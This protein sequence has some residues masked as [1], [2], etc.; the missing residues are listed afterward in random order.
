MWL[1]V[2]LIPREL[3]EYGLTANKLRKSGYVYVP[4][5]SKLLVAAVNLTFADDGDTAGCYTSADVLGN[6]ISC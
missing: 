5:S 6:N 1:I 4:I 2:S 3:I